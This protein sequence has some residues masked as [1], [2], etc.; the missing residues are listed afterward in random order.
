[1]HVKKLILNLLGARAVAGV[2]AEKPQVVESQEALPW[3]I[4]ERQAVDPRHGRPV[5]QH[6]VL[7]KCIL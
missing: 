3:A 7:E 2:E 6:T 5:H 4:E 1:M